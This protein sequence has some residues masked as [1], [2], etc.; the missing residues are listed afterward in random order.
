MPLSLTDK[1]IDPACLPARPCSAPLSLSVSARTARKSAF[2]SRWGHCRR[3]QTGQGAKGGRRG[4]EIWARVFLFRLRASDQ[5]T[6]VLSFLFLVPI[7]E[8]Q[9]PAREK[10]TPPRR[11]KGRYRDGREARMCWKFRRWADGRRSWDLCVSLHEAYSSQSGA[12]VSPKR[13]R[14][15]ARKKNLSERV[16]LQ[17]RLVFSPQ[18]GARTARRRYERA[19]TTYKVHLTASLFAN[20]SRPLAFYL[21]ILGWDGLNW[22]CRGE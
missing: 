12:S 19:Q 9:V 2:L 14:E 11:G 13:E 8:F 17:I 16:S 5:G 15:K 21:T 4:R 20:S 6:G 3:G 22:R 1:V 10:T 18:D 7:L